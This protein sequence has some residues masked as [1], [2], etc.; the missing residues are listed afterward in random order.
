MESAPP[1]TPPSDS[2]ICGIL[3]KWVNYGKGWRA[4]WFVLQDGVLSFFKIHG[5]N[6][7]V[8]NQETEKGSRVIGEES[9]K[10]MLRNHKNGSK[11]SSSKT[12]NAVGE[13]HLKVSSIR[14]SQSDGKR[15]SIYTGT[16][17][18][19]LKAECREDRMAWIEALQAV[20]DKFPRISNSE[21]MAPVD[22]LAVSTEKLRQ[23]LLEEGLSEVAIQDSEQIM[24]DEFTS[25]QNQLLLL[26]QK[27][28]LLMDK[29]R[30]LEV[31]VVIRRLTLGSLNSS[32]VSSLNNS[33]RQSTI[34]LP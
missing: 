5:P 22:N 1:Q 21:L 28:C 7:I 20:K 10:L 15:F 25:M 13:I 33:A 26:K 8:V 19:H 32:S 24:K 17:R 3:Y 11:H 4:R 6:K 9:M 29:V 12:W 14:E 34:S 30:Q 23:R 27:Q 18:L 16:K 31:H 2:M